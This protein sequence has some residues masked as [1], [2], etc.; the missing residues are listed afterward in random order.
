MAESVKTREAERAPLAEGL[1]TTPTAQLAPGARLLPHVLLPFVKSAAFVP[2]TLMVLIAIDAVL[3]F[4]RVAVCVPLLDPTFTLPKDRE[5][6]LTLAPDVPRPDSA[7][8]CVP[9]ESVKVRV[10]VRLPAVVGANTTFTV[11]LVDA[12]RLVPQVLLKIRKSPALVPPIA[13]L[14]MVMAVVLV[15]E[16]VATF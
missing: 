10:A 7:T 16:S 6:G 9:A 2:V 11:Q 4:F 12:A 13:M 3:P 15:L 1:K 8:V 5:A 14:L